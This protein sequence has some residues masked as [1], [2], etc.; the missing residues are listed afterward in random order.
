MTTLGQ[1]A[2][3]WT[4]SH[5]PMCKFATYKMDKIIYLYCFLV[6]KREQPSL[7]VFCC[8]TC[9]HGRGGWPLTTCKAWFPIFRKFCR[10]KWYKWAFCDSMQKYILQK[11]QGRHAIWQAQVFTGFYKLSRNLICR[12]DAVF[13]QIKRYLRYSNRHRWQGTKHQK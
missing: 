1:H 3:C 4:G 2:V 8:P 7:H 13:T 5:P 11:L 9:R 6:S 12:N 10:C